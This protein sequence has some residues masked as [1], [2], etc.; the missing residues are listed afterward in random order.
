MWSILI[1]RAVVLGHLQCGPCTARNYPDRTVRTRFGIQ[2]GT[3]SVHGPDWT[4]IFPQNG[5]KPR[6]LCRC[7][8]RCHIRV[9]HLG[10]NRKPLPRLRPFPHEMVVAHPCRSRLLQSASAAFIGLERAQPLTGAG[11]EATRRPKAPPVLRLSLCTH[12]MP[13]RH[14]CT[15]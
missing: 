12:S 11:I 10:P 2:D 1:P 3:S 9:G 13:E 15:G 14:D 4:F 7:P 8:G 5:G 6:G